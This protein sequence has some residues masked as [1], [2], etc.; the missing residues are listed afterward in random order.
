M[1]KISKKFL[2]SIPLAL[3]SLQIFLGIV[4][5]YFLGKLFSGKKPGQPGKIKSIIFYIGRYKLHLHHWLVFLSILILNLLTS[6][7]FPFP[8]FSLSLLSGL[9]IQGIVCYPDWHRILVRQG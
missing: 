2:L 8:K 9:M 5:G 1:V 4:L 3:I 7:F 6:L